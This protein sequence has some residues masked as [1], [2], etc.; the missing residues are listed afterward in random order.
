[1]Q[2][3]GLGAGPEVGVGVQPGA[4]GVTV[5]PAPVPVAAAAQAPASADVHDEAD[6]TSVLRLDSLERLSRRV[7]DV[8]ARR[9]DVS[10]AVG[11]PAQRRGTARWLA[12]AGRLLAPGQARPGEYDRARLFAARAAVLLAGPATGASAAHDDAAEAAR[13]FEGTGDVLAAAAGHAVAALA[14]VRAGTVGQALDDAVQALVAFGSLSDGERDPDGEAYL[15]ELLGRLCHQ[16][17]D[18]ERALQF[19]EL[20]ARSLRDAP[21][22]AAGDARLA[23]VQARLGDLL[24]HQGADAAAAREAL[25]ER[26]CG[27]ARSLLDG[28]ARPEGLRLLAAAACER[29]RCGEGLELLAGFPGSEPLLLL[30]RARC[31]H[32]VGDDAGALADLDAAVGAC[33]ADGDLA[34]QID[35]LEVR[36][37]VREAVGDLAGALDDARLLGDLVWQRHR[38]QVGGF[39]DQVWSRAGVEGQRRDL[40]ARARVLLRFAEQDPLT[41]LANRRAIEQFCASMRASEQVCLVLVDVDHFKDVN[42]RHGHL[43]GDA[44]LREVASVLS[45]SV[46]SVDRVAR[47][48]GEEFLV[49]LPGGTAVLG[50]EAAG[51]LRR[52]I[53]EHA[54]SQHA[55]GLRLTVSAGVSSGRAGDFAAVLARADAALYAAKGAGRNRVVSS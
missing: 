1:V 55:P 27:I 20:A 4:R 40:E 54:W 33:A 31:R 19:Y 25:L 23:R 46:R 36:S 7:A 45:G 24:L 26:A 21:A 12:E 5:V 35:A 9:P 52:R 48:G 43:V 51:R 41:N 44:V 18:H 10:A 17:F 34:L 13:L 42:D 14:A 47:W 30:T 22:S 32:S 50:A 28:P 15:A 29:G 37:R 49:A 2:V 16:F 11:P 6:G 53:E 39:M 8:L 3:D 38:R